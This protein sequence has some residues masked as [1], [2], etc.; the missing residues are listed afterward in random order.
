M[1]SFKT[2]KFFLKWFAVMSSKCNTSGRIGDVKSAI[3][4]EEILKFPFFFLKNP[5]NIMG[6]IIAMSEHQMT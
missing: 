6:T 5:D 4:N 1:T 2:T 3:I